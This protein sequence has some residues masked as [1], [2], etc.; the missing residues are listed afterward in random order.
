[1]KIVTFVILAICIVKINSNTISRHDV[2][3]IN[4]LEASYIL[5]QLTLPF[6]PTNH[7][8]RASN[9]TSSSTS[10]AISPSSLISQLLTTFGSAIAPALG[11]FAPI[12]TL[13]G[14]WLNNYLSGLL[15]REFN[16]IGGMVQRDDSTSNDEIET[17]HITFPNQGKYTLMMQ[18]PQQPSTSI[19]NINNNMFSMEKELQ[20]LVLEKDQSESEKRLDPIAKLIFNILKFL[21]KL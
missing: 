7:G 13:V 9:S 19:N 20:S 4:A 12:A 16:S 5:K 21:I 6:T 18:R 8:T 10:S 1:M 17:V 11:P 2:Y 3:P 14:G 15:S